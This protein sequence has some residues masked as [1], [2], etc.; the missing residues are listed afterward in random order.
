MIT[1]CADYIYL[2]SR[3]HG[4]NEGKQILLLYARPVVHINFINPFSNLFS[5][6]MALKAF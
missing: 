3:I 6:F 4:H 5:D 2:E 1:F